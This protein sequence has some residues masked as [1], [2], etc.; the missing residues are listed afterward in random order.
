MRFAITGIAHESNSF[1]PEMTGLN[2]FRVSDPDEVVRLYQSAAA[3]ITGYFRACEAAGVQ[4]VPLSH[5]RSGASGTVTAEAYTTLLDNMVAELEANGPFD[6]VLLALHGAMVAE[7]QVDADGEILRR[8]R[9]L[10]GPDVPVVASLDMH[11]NVSKGMVEH[12]T[13]LTI[14]RTNPHVDPE[15]RAREAAEIAIAVARGEVKPTSALRQ[16][17][18]A[19]NILVQYTDMDPMKALVTELEKVLEQ[20]G[21]L[22]ASLAEGYPWGDVEAMGMAVLVVTDDDQALADQL[23]DELAAKVWARREEFDAEGV[24]M[25]EAV[26]RAMEAPQQPVLLLD[27][28]DNVG[29]GS[30]GDSVALLH[31]VLR[32][33]ATDVYAAVASPS[34]VAAC[35]AAGVG[36]EV[37]VEVG[38]ATDPAIG[39]PLRLQGTV[40][41]ISDGTYEDPKPTHGGRRFFDMGTAAVVDLGNNVKVLLTSNVI[42]SSTPVQLTSVGLDPMSF[43]AIIAK[44]V[45]SPLAGY[46]PI[47]AEWMWVDT[48]GCTAASFKNLPFTSRRSPM[49]PFE[50]DFDYA[51]GQ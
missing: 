48:P 20:P 25:D 13:A 9:E 36:A 44:G 40:R 1:A 19:I 29:G 8:V 33:G 24:P 41:V 39:P 22:T 34:G 51:G 50:T 38:A 2:R 35:I 31:E 14:Y 32:Q 21:V 16:I 12:S 45:N 42:G 28:G 49:F 6:G 3:T 17:P 7:G 4:A 15:P 47:V 11:A 43:K 23:A 30:P 26:R 5:A 27:V 10:V 18:A 37:D 46:M